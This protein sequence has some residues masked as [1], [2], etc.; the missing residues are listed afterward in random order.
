MMISKSRK[1]KDRNLL[2]HEH[3]ITNTMFNLAI[4]EF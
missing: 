1:D 2:K 3:G 4:E